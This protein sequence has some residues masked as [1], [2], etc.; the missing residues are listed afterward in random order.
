MIKVEVVKTSKQKKQFLE[1]ANELYKGNK[2]FVPPLYI[3]EKKIFDS[4]YYY[5][6]ECDAEYFLAY[7]DSDKVVGRISAFIQHSSNKKTGEKRARFGR[8]DAI[9]SQEVANALF[10]TAVKWSKER[11]MEKICGPLGFSDLEREGLLIEGFDV[12]QT[13]EEQYNYAYYQKLVENYG[14]KKEVDWLEY[15]IRNNP[16][17]FEKIQKIASYVS[18]KNNVRLAEPQN[19][20]KLIKLYAEQVFDLIDISYRDLYGTVDLS[21][22]VRKELIKQFKFL[23]VTR[24]VNCIINE[25]DRIVAFS[26]AFPNIGE[27]MQVAGGHLTLRALLKLREILKHPKVID[28]GLIAVH[29]DYRNKGLNAIYMKLISDWLAAGKSEHF[30]TNLD[31]ETNVQVQA[32]WKYFDVRKV[33][34]RRCFVL[35]I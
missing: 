21:E 13:F 11:G 20:K 32:L 22:K 33:K 12:I 27:A 15:Q 3:N 18:R 23:L 31:L 8:F 2:Y 28:M 25:R 1:F 30:E 26:V 19:V 6:D 24:S 29:P 14:F 16:N 9:D 35:D 34:R 17:C 10:D 7:D 4:N 5:Y